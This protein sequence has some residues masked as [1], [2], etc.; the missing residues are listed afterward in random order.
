MG[1]H[2][3]GMTTYNNLSV[4]TTYVLFIYLFIVNR[5]VLS[6]NPRLTNWVK[7]KDNVALACQG[8]DVNIN[9]NDYEGIRV[10][11]AF[12]GRDNKEDCQ[13][14]DPLSTMTDKET[15]FHLD[16]GYAY[17]KVAEICQ[18]HQSCQVIGTS[19][20]FD[21]SMCPHIK[22]FARINYECRQLSGMRRSM[23]HKHKKGSK[24]SHIIRRTKKKRK[25]KKRK[26][27]HH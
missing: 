3:D 26:F 11:D 8:E 2:V 24:K 21:T 4:N 13:V 10:K 25:E 6:I 23:V 9:C 20:N 19:L 17:N 1:I 15:C 14:D 12:W 18:G 27:H 5:F 16:K 7:T 22:K